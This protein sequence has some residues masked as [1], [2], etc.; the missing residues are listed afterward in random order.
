M[1]SNT[2]AGVLMN[3]MRLTIARSIRLRV[4]HYLRSHNLPMHVYRI[5]ELHVVWTLLQVGVLLWTALRLSGGGSFGTS[6]IVDGMYV[7]GGSIDFSSSG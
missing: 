5:V 3:G 1:Q 7:L 2:T 6:S 4:V